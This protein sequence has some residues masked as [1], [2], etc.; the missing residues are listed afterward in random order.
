MTD[1]VR[2]RMDFAARGKENVFSFFFLIENRMFIRINF[3]N[4][5]EVSI[6]E[7]A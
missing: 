7:M 1:K 6:K 2:L 5:E 3:P 4:K